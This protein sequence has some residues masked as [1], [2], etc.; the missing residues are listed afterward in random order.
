MRAVS[1]KNILQLFAGTVALMLTLAGC[2]GG[3]GTSGGTTG[4]TT[5][6]G[7]GGTP[8]PT[9]TYTIGGNIAGL[10]SGQSVV[11]QDNGG[12]NLTLSTNG[13][14]AFV[15]GLASNSTYN[16][17]V[18]TQPANGQVCSV[19]AGSGTVATSNVTSVSVTCASKVGGYLVGLAAGQ[20]IVL[21]NNAGDNLIVSANGAFTFA[22]PVASYNV[23]V[24]TQPTNGQICA[25][26]KNVTL[27]S[28]STG[29]G[30]VT[31]GPVNTVRLSC[32]S[33]FTFA[34][35]GNAGVG[36]A[37]GEDAAFSQPSGMTMDALGNLYVISVAANTVQKITPA[38]VVTTLAGSGAAGYV[39]GSGTAAQFNFLNTVNIDFSGIAVDSAGNVYVADSGNNMIRKISSAGVVTTLA[40]QLT[41][42]Y[43]NATG[44]AAQFKA[45]Q[46]VAVD[47]LG[48]VYVADSGNS[49]IRMITAAGVVTTL[50]GSGA[51]G[52][53]DGTGTAAQFVWPQ[54]MAM[55]ASNNLYVAEGGSPAA[56]RKITTPG[57]VVTTLAGS[58][59]GYLD[60]IGS[61]AKFK[62][63][64]A[65]AVDASGN[66]Y[67]SEFGNT[68]IRV[69][70]PAGGVSTIA[71][72]F[73]ATASSLDGPVTNASL[74]WPQGLAVDAAG[75]VY[76][77]DTGNNRIRKISA[78]PYVYTVSGHVDGLAAGQSVT[79][80]NNLGN[81]LTLSA[82]G[83]FT[84]SAPLITAQTYSVTV[85]TQPAGQTCAVVNG[86]G[87]YTTGDVLNVWVNCA[88]V[89]T[90]AGSGT[91]GL[92]N[93]TT[94]LNSQ[95]KGPSQL[96]YD[97]LG[98]LYVADVTNEV[99]RKIT[100]AGVVSTL[101]GSGTMG[102]ANGTGTAANFSLYA[103]SG[104]AVD[105]SGNVYVGDTG[106]NVIRRI[107]A[108]GVVSTLVGNNTTCCYQ[109][110]TGSAAWFYMPGGLALDGLGNLYVADTGNHSIRKIVLSGAVVTTLAG[111]GGN[112]NW[113][114]VNG[115]GTLAR[116][117]NPGGIAVGTGGM[118]YVADGS[119]G[120]V[121]MINPSTA[122]VTTLAGH[123]GA[124]W[125]WSG[126]IDAS[127]TAAL[128]GGPSSI[129]V[130]AA[131][132]VYVT[133]GTIRMI[134]PTGTVTTWAGVPG[135]GFTYPTPGYVNGNGSV[136]QFS[137]GCSAGAGAGGSGIAIDA[138]GNLIVGDS[139]NNVIRKI[140][141]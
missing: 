45:P 122:V 30:S 75:N 104:L 57:A 131:G 48:N 60:E 54:G 56:I 138:S 64:E 59:S 15:T 41:A 114:Y 33:M 126:Y 40:G 93:G 136:A 132:N 14:F 2:G 63:P 4:G 1:T 24:L 19:T 66:V 92:I 103:N 51:I 120:A 34:G 117:N 100:P 107:T 130:D 123:S 127:G 87:G 9:V 25:V 115:V 139:C 97:S 73:G 43:L 26:A 140:V 8:I 86:A 12:D 106:N 134:S 71:G 112:T 21:Q 116:F 67:V 47:S 35:S 3:G 72:P 6:G 32:A 141:P 77:A 70:S 80:Q 7:A 84:F 94:L 81:N 10:A 50:A 118:L 82:N 18:L 20:S 13:G 91:A 95:F 119:N 5:G 121:R 17:T 42:G 65:V 74:Y 137:M 44:A 110:G 37:M 101:A 99:I 76:V 46:G 53:V 55:D 52:I 96:A 128:F 88:M 11:L 49:V 85:A 28:G 31:S 62:Q 108:A 38:G 29:I 129:A 78:A 69:V 16:V 23:T 102:Y 111:G 68:T 36:N 105:A 133:D 124:G 98:N 22:T 58:G 39:D 125:M 83:Y 27:L 90:Y 61:A 79:L 89:S 135:G 113:G 109:D